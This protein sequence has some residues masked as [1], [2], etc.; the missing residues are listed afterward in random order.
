MIGVSVLRLAATHAILLAVERTHEGDEPMPRP[1]QIGAGSLP[2][3]KGKPG[4]AAN[5]IIELIRAYVHAPI[6]RPE[7]NIKRI[8]EVRHILD[9]L[10]FEAVYEAVAAANAPG[11]GN[12][13]LREMEAAI[14]VHFQT[15]GGYVAIGR[16]LLAEEDAS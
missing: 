9:Y 8:E 5:R 15:L 14:G 1:S 11:E 7:A 12:V 6:D 10:R 3:V 16:R 2:P 4:R 13:S